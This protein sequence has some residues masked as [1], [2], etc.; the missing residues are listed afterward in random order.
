MRL[1]ELAATCVRLSHSAATRGM[2]VSKKRIYR[3][4]CDEGLII[5][6][7]PKPQKGMRLRLLREQLPG[8]PG[9]RRRDRLL[10]AG[11]A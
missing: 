9:G 2:A 7:L 1:K 10:T 11:K 8:P 6:S 3:L 5:R 4:Y